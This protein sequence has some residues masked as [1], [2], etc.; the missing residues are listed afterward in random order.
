MAD[1]R[2]QARREAAILLGVDI[3][4]MSPADSLRVDM[5]SALRLVIDAEQAAVLSGGQ[6]DLG[7]LNVA[8]QSLIAL[9][10]GR[11]LPAP[12]ASG[13]SPQEI[14]LATYKR[15]RER[16]ELAGDE[17]SFDFQRRRRLELEAEV[18]SKDARI[19]ELEATTVPL[20]PN[21]VKLRKDNPSPS[22]NANHGS[23]LPSAASAAPPKPEP[24]PAAASAPAAPRT[25]DDTP[26][27]QAWNSWRDDGGYVRD[28][29]SNN[30]Y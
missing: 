28:R 17:N 29:W 27:G 19:A 10:P 22:A 7:K 30:N 21:A 13:P 24:P 12:T 18:A 15:M 25:W 6:A 16:G 9:L 11:E 23:V 8:V 3:E 4:H 2:A 26:G 14:M 5:I 20:P 1:D